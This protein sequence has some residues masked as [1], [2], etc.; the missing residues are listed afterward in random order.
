MAIRRNQYNRIH[1]IITDDYFGREQVRVNGVTVPDTNAP[2]WK[3]LDFCRDELMCSPFTLI[4]TDDEN[5]PKHQ[6]LFF[7]VNKD[8]L[9][10]FEMEYFPDFP[11]KF[12]VDFFDML[13]YLDMVPFNAIRV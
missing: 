3:F 2:E 11:G 13:V 6:R 4:F 1:S 9:K 12:E 10:V 8:A 7:H 5:I